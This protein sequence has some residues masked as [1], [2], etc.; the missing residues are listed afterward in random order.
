VSVPWDDPLAA[1]QV[2]A[3]AAG[4]LVSGPGRWSIAWCAGRGTVA[5]TAEDIDAEAT[6]FAW[7]VDDLAAAVQGSPAAADGAVF[8]A[9]SAGGAYAGSS[10]P[11]F[12]E[13]SPPAAVSPYGS[14][15]LQIERMVG[16]LTERTG[17][18]S[19]VARIA[20][21]YGPGQDLSKPQG[22]VSQLCR[23]MITRQPLSIYVPLD[24]IRDYLYVDDCARMV[25]QGL[26]EV[27]A[28]RTADGAG[29]SVLKIM[30]SHQP[31]TV[32]ALIGEL[33]RIAKRR[34]PLVLGASPVANLQPPDLRLRSEV[35]THLDA[36]ASTPLAVGLRATIDDVGAAVR[37]A[38][39]G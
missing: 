23:A 34:P 20:N 14:M 10:P 11:P 5:T 8:V 19:L 12:S 22:L 3:D 26:D 32:S 37:I 35:W 7:F 9:S 39:A 36:L 18:P 24:T 29:E 21:L 13:S 30:A 28:C 33:T 4:A 38:D 27:A 31:T 16:E 6:T 17:V 25:L 2:L 1:R 15:K